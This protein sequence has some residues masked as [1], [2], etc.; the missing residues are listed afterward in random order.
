MFSKY[1]SKKNMIQRIVI[2][3]KIFFNS[4]I[5]I[6]LAYIHYTVQVSFI[7]SKYFLY[8]ATLIEHIV[9]HIEHLNFSVKN[10]I[11]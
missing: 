4:C 8:Q 10:N 9:F 3:A 5:N 11:C 6:H 2:I 1:F 7:S